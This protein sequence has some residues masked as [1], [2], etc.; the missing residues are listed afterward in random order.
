MNLSAISHHSRFADCYGKNEEE[1]TINIRT[2]KDITGVNLLFDD[3]YAY[4]ISGDIHWVGR[5]VSMVKTRELK[6]NDIYS[7]TVRP[8]YRRLQYYFELFGE[9]ES[10]FLYEDDFY[11]REEAEKL[12][13]RSY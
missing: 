4:G 7:V 1:L 2:G 10:V 3:P 11:T 8:E 9:Q 13:S 5:P 6:H 12:L